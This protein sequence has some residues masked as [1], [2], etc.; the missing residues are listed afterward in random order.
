MDA[1]RWGA[2]VTHRR[3][4]KSV[5][6]I[7]HLIKAAMTST[8]E[9]PRYAYIGP[10]FTQAKAVIFDYLQH[11]SQPIPDAVVNHS[12]LRV[13]YP[14]GSQVRLF[15]ADNPDSLRGLY[16]D[17]CVL[18][19]FGLMRGNVFSEVLRPLLADRQGWALFQGTPNGKNQFYDVVQRAQRE[20]GWFCAL[21]K[22]SQTGILSPDELEDAKRSMSEDEYAQEFECSFEASVKGA[23]F[24]REVAQARVDGRIT[25]VPYDPALP[26]D[27]DWD[28]GV[29]DA[30]SIWFSQSLRSREVRLVDYYEATGQGL[31]HYKAILDRK[32]YT[33]GEMWGPHDISVREFGSG[34]ARIDTAR[35]LGINFR[36]TP[37]VEHLEDGIHSAR[38]LFPRCWFDADKCAAGIEALQHYRWDTN[39]RIKEFTHIPVHD[40]ASHGADAFRGLSFR[41]YQSMKSPEAQASADLRKAQQDPGESWTWTPQR[42]RGRGGYG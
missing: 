34:N 32:P 8:K 38:M 14:N 31:A 16:L 29:G 18:D 27:T 26:V 11:F 33:Y 6:A 30:T 25:R 3:F 40:W 19:E 15:G 21:Y 39:Q 7:N 9:R 13:D 22:A 37:K 23:I 24:A 10:T 36:I 5:L 35:Q 1:H 41:H 12:E 17:G 42:R 4:G 20:P 2:I 28:L